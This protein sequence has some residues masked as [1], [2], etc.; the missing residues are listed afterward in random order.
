MIPDLFFLSDHC[1]VWYL[2]AYLFV[3]LSVCSN[4][5]SPS[6]MLSCSGS[7]G[8][9]ATADGAEQSSLTL[10]DI[11][12]HAIKTV[13]ATLGDRDRISIVSFESSARVEC[14][15]TTVDD[16]GRAA[17]QAKVDALRDGGGT[18]LW[19]GLLLGLEILAQQQALDVE[20][21][22]AAQ[23]PHCKRNVAIL[24]L[25]DGDAPTEP[26]GG[27]LPCMRQ[28]AEM[29]GNGVY[30]GLCRLSALGIRLTRNYCVSWRSRAVAPTRSFPIV[31]LS[32]QCL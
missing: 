18:N 7:M 14:R 11:V 10:L 26:P 32:E 31:D 30:P 9:R 1:V 19:A 4:S 25:T 20:H 21:A 6:R 2:S 15:L 29:R 22:A 3:C 23:V 16:V 8:S 17:V 13:L 28:W 27:H 24:L 12:K 5:L